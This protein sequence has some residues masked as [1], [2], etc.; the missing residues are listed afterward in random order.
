MMILLENVE[1]LC[2]RQSEL[3]FSYTFSMYFVL[4]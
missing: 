3:L 4:F 1:I 2:L